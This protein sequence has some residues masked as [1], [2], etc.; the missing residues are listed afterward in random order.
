MNQLLR[1]SWWVSFRQ[2]SIISFLLRMFTFCFVQLALEIT[3]ML[4]KKA[5]ENKK[6]HVR[7]S[8]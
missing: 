5:F 6:K 4:T 8:L 1:F 2:V 3:E 7:S